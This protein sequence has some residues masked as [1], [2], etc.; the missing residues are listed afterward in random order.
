M[1]NLLQRGSIV[2]EKLSSPFCFPDY[3]QSFCSLFLL[4]ILL[5]SLYLSFS[6]QSSTSASL[7]D[8]SISLQIPSKASLF[9]PMDDFDKVDSGLI[10]SSRGFRL[11]DF[12]LNGKD[13]FELDD[14]PAKTKTYLVPLRFLTFP[15]SSP[16]DHLFGCICVWKSLDNSSVFVRDGFLGF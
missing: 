11:P 12:K 2:L 4:L 13:D 14:A 10:S 5:S 16:I 15:H 7:S 6:V 8:A 1:R 9:S 3:E